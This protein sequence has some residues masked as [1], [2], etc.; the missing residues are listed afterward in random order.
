MVWKTEGD[1]G[2]KPQCARPA[3]GAEWAMASLAL[4][5]PAARPAAGD[6]DADAPLATQ[7]GLAFLLSF[8]AVA[9]GL[10]AARAATTAVR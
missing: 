8:S 3:G 9:V 5:T 4:P 7:V 10:G 1:I 2:G 6:A